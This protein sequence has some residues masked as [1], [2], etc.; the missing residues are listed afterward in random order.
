MEVAVGALQ[1]VHHVGGSARKAWSCKLMGRGGHDED[2][3]GATPCQ[4]AQ[5]A[6]P[7]RGSNISQRELRAKDHGDEEVADEVQGR[8]RGAP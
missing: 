5:W 8:C 2:P 6:V 3:R 1:D 4:K 7:E